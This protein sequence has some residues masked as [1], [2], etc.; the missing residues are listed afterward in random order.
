[1]AKILDKSAIIK[2]RAEQKY[3][4]RTA[5]YVGKKDSQVESKAAEIVRN[6]KGENLD[7]TVVMSGEKW[8]NSPGYAQLWDEI[9]QAQKSLR[10]NFSKRQNIATFPDDYYDLIDKIR[11]D[12][13]RR[14][15]E[16][17]DYTDLLTQVI[18][19]DNFSKSVAL[20]E[21]LPYAAVFEEVSLAGDSPN[22]IDQKT[23]ETTSAVMTAYGVGHARTLEDEIYNTDIYSLEKVNRAVARGHRSKR[24]DLGILGRMVAKTTAGGWDSGQQVAADTT[25]STAEAKL[26]NT[27]SSAIDTLMGLKDPATENE[28]TASQ[29][30]LACR[31]GDVRRINRVINGQLNIG[32]K[33]TPA[34]FAALTE[35]T[36]LIPYNGDV[37]YRGKE[38][39]TYAGIA[40]DT[41]YLFVPGRAGA[42][43][44]TLEKRSLTQEMTVR[45]FLQYA[46]DG[47]IWYFVQSE[48]FADFFG[49]SQTGTSLSTGYGWVVEV[50]LP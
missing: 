41:A 15:M 2:Q 31:P 12:I 50:T 44:Y 30:V 45:P 38:K 8:E 6:N 37:I 48:Y 19:N 26:Y 46:S 43:L 47:R 4:L 49:S 29:L 13:T 7:A 23:G 9:E 28:I 5:H 24:N 3:A 11:I 14:R 39:V 10:N 20:D 33:G 40:E 16:E 17:E 25:G 18:A 22:L 32:G 34:N 36:D 21:F 35:I 1:M 27:L 42:P